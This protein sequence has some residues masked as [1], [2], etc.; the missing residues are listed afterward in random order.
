MVGML[1]WLLSSAKGKV[2]LLQHEHAVVMSLEPAQWA[3]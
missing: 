3:I 2:S 1:S